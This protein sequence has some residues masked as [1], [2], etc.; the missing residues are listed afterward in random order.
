MTILLLGGTGEARELASRL[1]EQGIEV[2]SS[3]AGRVKRPRLPVGQTRVGG[4]GG[5]AGLADWLRAHHVRA[6]VDATHPF[7]DGITGNAVAACHDTGVPLLRLE[8][9]GWSGEPGAPSWTWVDSAERAAD[10]AATLGE[11]PFLTC[12]RQSL[13]AFLQPLARR[14]ALVRVVDPPEITLPPTWTLLLDRGP[15]LLAEEELR[16]REYAVDVLVTKDSGGR[17]T[18]PKLEAAGRLD[19]PVVIIR[20]TSNLALAEAGTPLVSDVADAVAWVERQLPR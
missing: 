9:A 17:L 19:L 4:F 2:V 10:A 20:R 15:Y 16:M 6:V 12:G 11:R 14:A 7:A 5:I 8:R 18:W 1:D 3:L 13:G